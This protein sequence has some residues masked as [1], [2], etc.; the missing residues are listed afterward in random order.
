MPPFTAK[1]PLYRAAPNTVVGCDE[2]IFRSNLV[3]CW[4][5]PTTEARPFAM[6]INH[7]S[8]CLR[9]PYAHFVNSDGTTA[10]ES[11]HG[12]VQTTIVV[13]VAYLLSLCASVHTI[14]PLPPVTHAS[15]RPTPFGCLPLTG[16][17]PQNNNCLQ[18]PSTCTLIITI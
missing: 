15:H 1:A 16:L 13:V 7:R 11:S 18:C 8:V 12:R 10:E 5:Y 4:I 9:K 14:S 3:H 2:P 17:P 6:M